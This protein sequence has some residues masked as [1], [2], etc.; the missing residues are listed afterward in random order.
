MSTRQGMSFYAT[1]AKLALAKF[2]REL[3]LPS[4]FLNPC[5]ACVPQV[6]N[7]WLRRSTAKKIILSAQPKVL[8]RNF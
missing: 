1:F 7:R 5:S 2:A 3:P 4:Y 8:L 6:D